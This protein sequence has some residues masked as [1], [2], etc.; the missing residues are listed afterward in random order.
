MYMNW[1]TNFMALPFNE[2]IALS[3]L[4]HMYRIMTIVQFT[5]LMQ[6]YLLIKFHGDRYSNIK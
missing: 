2:E 3:Q 5:D 1:F 6:S 4:K